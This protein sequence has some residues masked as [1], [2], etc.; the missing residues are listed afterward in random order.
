MRASFT[1]RRVPMKK[2][3]RVGVLSMA[4][5]QAGVCALIALVFI[6][7]FL[8]AGVLG[9]ALPG[10]SSAAG[11]VGAIFMCIVMPILYGIF[12]FIFGAIWAFVYNL[13]A[14]RMGGI[15]VE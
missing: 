12:G 5:M 6:P 11:L 7:F 3:K 10:Q 15:E 13:V 2:G 4:K 14:A 9:M 8:L 1:K